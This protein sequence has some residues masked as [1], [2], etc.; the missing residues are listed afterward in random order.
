ME[1]EWNYVWTALFINFLVVTLVPKLIKKP[2]GVRVVDDVV[3]FLTSQKDMLLSSSIVLA[4]VIYGSLIDV[5]AGVLDGCFHQ[6][7]QTLP[8][9][10]I[11]RIALAQFSHAWTKKRRHP[12]DGEF[13]RQLAS[14]RTAHAIGDSN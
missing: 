6:T 10:R 3:L 1:M 11:L 4:L 13:A 14:S 12:F 8:K 9:A 2:T 5:L 7:R